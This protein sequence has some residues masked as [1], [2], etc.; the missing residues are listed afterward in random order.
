[1]R[2]NS[3]LGSTE[4]S[5]SYTENSNCVPALQGS[6]AE[7]KVNFLEIKNRLRFLPLCNSVVSLKE[8]H[9]SRNFH[10]PYITD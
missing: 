2:R 6:H 3:T 7:L 1:M 9:N 8:E 10:D 5:H 4:E